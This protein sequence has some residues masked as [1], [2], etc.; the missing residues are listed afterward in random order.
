MTSGTSGYLQNINPD[1]IPQNGYWV[2]YTYDHTTDRYSAWINGSEV[3]KV[4]DDTTSGATPPTS[5]PARMDFGRDVSVSAYLYGLTEFSASCMMVG[6]GYLGDIDAAKFIYSANTHE[7][8]E[9]IS[10]TNEW[11]AG[12]DS[13]VTNVGSVDLTLDPSASADI[14]FH[15]I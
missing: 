4:L 6:D 1:R 9:G 7:D 5:T 15:Q 8:M 3:F 11:L 13:F 14:E 2:V 12:S 10:P